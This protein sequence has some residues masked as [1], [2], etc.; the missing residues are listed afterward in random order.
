ME[1]QNLYHGVIGLL[2]SAL[3]IITEGAAITVFNSDKNEFNNL[4]WNFSIQTTNFNK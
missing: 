4:E 1:N 3:G 2:L